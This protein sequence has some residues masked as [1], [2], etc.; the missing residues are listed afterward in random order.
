VVPN[1]DIDQMI[2]KMKSDKKNANGNINFTLLTKIGEGI[3]NQ[4]I[5]ENDI[6]KTFS[7]I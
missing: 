1:F 4:T 2:T 5:E 3:I 7:K 6:K